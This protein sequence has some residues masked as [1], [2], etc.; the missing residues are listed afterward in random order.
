MIKV[1][2]YTADAC[3]C[4]LEPQHDGICPGRY[5]DQ[6]MIESLTPLFTEG[7]SAAP[8]GEKTGYTKWM[9]L[10]TYRWLREKG[11]TADL[12]QCGRPASHRGQCKFRGHR[13]K[14]NPEQ[15]QAMGII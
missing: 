7:I 15:V 3:P 14:L 1:L 6:V 12:C 4:G 13:S 8:A 5:A 11:F 2:G 10:K 9:V